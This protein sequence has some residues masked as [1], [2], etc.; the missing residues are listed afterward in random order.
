LA[1]TNDFI[2]LAGGHNIFSE[3][4]LDYFTED[5]NEVGALNPDVIILSSKT[6]TRWSKQIFCH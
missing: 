4:L 3:R 5:F 6:V 2:H 1:F